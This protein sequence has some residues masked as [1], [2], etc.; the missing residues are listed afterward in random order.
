MEWHCKQRCIENGPNFHFPQ[1]QGGDQPCTDP[2]LVQHRPVGLYATLPSCWVWEGR[3]S[4]GDVFKNTH[5]KEESSPRKEVWVQMQTWFADFRTFTSLN[6]FS[7]SH[8]WKLES[9]DPGMQNC[10][11]VVESKH[12]KESHLVSLLRVLWIIY[13]Y[14]FR[15]HI[16]KLNLA[17][18]HTLVCL[19]AQY[20]IHTILYS[21]LY[22]TLFADQQRNVLLPWVGCQTTRG[23][24]SWSASTSTGTK[25]FVFFPLQKITS[26]PG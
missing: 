5:R 22:Y 1:T 18:M 15:N 20:T 11:L 8:R 24:I 12:A 17:K 19:R 7:L 3:N 10:A 4:E 2:G 6:L 9:C 21:I 26:R 23:Y 14:Q 16:F 13:H 25:C